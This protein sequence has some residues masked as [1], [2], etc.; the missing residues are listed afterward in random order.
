MQRLVVLVIITLLGIAP[1]GI[2]GRSAS[3]QETPTP[4]ATEATESCELL[5]DAGDAWAGVCRPIPE[6]ATIAAPYQP[7]AVAFTEEFAA[8][9]VIGDGTEDQPKAEFMVVHVKRGDFALDLDTGS[10]PVVVSTSQAKIETLTSWDPTPPHYATTGD[11]LKFNG[12]VCTLGCP[13]SPGVPVLLVPGDVVIAEKGALCIY[14]LLHGS[15]DPD[16]SPGLLEVFVLLDPGSGP[17]DFTWIRPWVESQGDLAATPSVSTEPGVM[18]W[19]LFN[20][21]RCDHG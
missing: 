3:A 10:Q 13:V 15:T 18:A 7:Y 11:S 9:E 8:T 1:I 5:E 6:D 17:D 14:C 16:G 4:P 20:P 2:V 21:G 12:A 19:A